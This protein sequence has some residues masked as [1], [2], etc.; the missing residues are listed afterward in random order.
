MKAKRLGLALALLLL[1]LLAL[2]PQPARASP[3]VWVMEERTLRTSDNGQTKTFSTSGGGSV[4][5]DGG[6]GAV[7]EAYVAPAVGV[8]DYAVTAGSWAYAYVDRVDYSVAVSVSSSS[9]RAPGWATGAAGS[10]RAAAPTWRIR[11]GSASRGAAASP[12]GPT[13]T[14]RRTAG[15][16]PAA[17]TTRRRSA[18]RSA[19]RR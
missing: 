13:R 11:R 4:D 12:G 1:L 14:P 17:A 9:T 8:S 16:C 6:Y 2:A 5:L 10:R 18:S 7:V 3:A 15:R 19:S